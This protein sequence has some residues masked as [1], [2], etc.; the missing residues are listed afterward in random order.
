MKK[1]DIDELESLLKNI[2]WES[3]KGRIKYIINNHDLID[4]DMDSLIVA[5]KTIYAVETAYE[6]LLENK[7]QNTTVL[8]WEKILETYNSLKEDE[9]QKEKLEEIKTIIKKNNAEIQEE[10]RFT[11]L[12]HYD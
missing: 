5:L 1:E 6:L 3:I 10:G 7:L 2:S 9:T 4:I 11:W 8:D 12:V